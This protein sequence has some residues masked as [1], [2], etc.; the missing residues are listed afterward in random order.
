MPAAKA[1]YCAGQQKPELFW[2]LHDWLF[3]N[4]A[5]WQSA[6][7][8][9]GQFRT[10]ALAL[11]ADVGKYDACITDSATETRIERDLAEGAALG[12]QGTPAFFVNDWF[13]SGAYPFEEFKDRIEKAKQGVHPAPTPTPLPAGKVFYDP[14]PNRAGRTY[15][16]SPMLGDAS[17]PLLMIQF[18]DLKSADAAKYAKET[19]PQLREKYITPGKV[20]VVYKLFPTEGPR[21]RLPRCAPRTRANSGNSATS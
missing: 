20:R 6:Q 21:P 19:E 18:D 16:G 13:L 12:I 9:A 3:A 8:A 5:A 11:G 10:Q 15:D 2:G 14:D 7:D 1:S 4:Q 17:A